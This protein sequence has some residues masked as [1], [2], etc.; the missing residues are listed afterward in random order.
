MIR[1]KEK[2]TYQYSKDNC[3]DATAYKALPRLFRRQHNQWR[4]SECL[5]KDKC[6]D[7]IDHHRPVANDHPEEAFEHVVR[8][9]G[10]AAYGYD[11]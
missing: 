10:A 5:P 1:N 11:G 9:E 7:V 2:N 3:G 6:H 4:S 8:Y